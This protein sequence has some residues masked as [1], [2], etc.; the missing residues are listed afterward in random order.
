MKDAAIGF[1]RF[2]DGEVP[3]P[4]AL[5]GRRVIGRVPEKEMPRGSSVKMWKSLNAKLLRK[6]DPNSSPEDPAKSSEGL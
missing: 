2:P 4:S 6:L 3:P 5:A 1:E